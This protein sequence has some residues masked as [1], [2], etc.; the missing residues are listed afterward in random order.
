MEHVDKSTPSTLPAAFEA[1]RDG[2]WGLCYRMTGSAADAEDLVQET[3]RRAPSSGRRATPDARGGRGSCGSRRGF[4]FDA[5]R[6]RRSR[7]YVGPWLPEPVATDTP[8]VT[9][10]LAADVATSNAE[11]RYGALES[12]TFAFLSALEALSPLQRAVLILREVVALTGPEV[13]ELLD[14]SPANVRVALHRARRAMEH[15]DACRVIPTEQ[16]NARALELMQRFMTALACNDVAAVIDLLRDDVAAVNDG[17]GVHHAAL[18]PVR[19]AD[20]VARFHQGVLERGGGVVGVRPVT[21]NY[22]PAWL[23]D[24]DPHRPRDAPRAM[25]RID[26]DPD[27]RVWQV[28]T[29]VAPAKLAPL[30]RGL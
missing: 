4:R 9:A 22:A 27:G 16:T 20:R 18:K 8:D 15:Y 25:T 3:F 19:G 11:V 5:L 29:I 1:H 30:F 13:A 28:H 26:I 21:V 10:R 23:L 12:A 17:A 6:R 2:V 7:G 24:L 14:I